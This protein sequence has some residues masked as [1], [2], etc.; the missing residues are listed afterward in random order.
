VDRLAVLLSAGPR[1]DGRLIAVGAFGVVLCVL[2]VGGT[3]AWAAYGVQPAPSLF[4]DT[5]NILAALECRRQGFDPLVDNPCDPWDRRL[6]YLRPWLALRWLGL[7][8]GHVVLVAA[9]VIGLFVLAVWLVIGRRS[10]GEG[11]VL[12]VCLC[13]P[14]VMFAVERANMDLVLFVLLAAAV[15]WWRRGLAGAWVGGPVLLVVAAVT[16]IYPVFALPA[17]VVTRSRRAVVGAAVAIMVAVVYLLVALEDVVTV[18]R[19]AP[20]GQHWS[21]GARILLAQA[22]QALVSEA[23]TGPLAAQAGAVLAVVVMGAGVW[24]WARRNLRPLPVDDR[25]ATAD[26]L[27]FL[28]GSAIY[29]GTFAVGNNFDYRLVFLLLTLPQLWTW[30]RSAE[31]PGTVRAVAML[32]LAMVVVAMWV[33]A[34]SQPLRLL[35]EL[36]S[37]AL[38][39]QLA[40]L[41]IAA[42]PSPA[43]LRRLVAGDVP[44]RV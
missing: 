16:K 19:T 39:L 12:A 35:D 18:A 30:E 27:G 5:R 7:H 23:G 21:Y 40:A 42:L 31:E 44:T 29:V 20:Q 14:S 34:W 26:R 36:V 9:V 15:I 8:Q 25:R 33:G 41:A 4:F 17:Y 43:D 13:S 2:L 22:Y 11:V 32:A 6:V 1:G 3:Q 38:A 28:F 37:W 10:L 24:W